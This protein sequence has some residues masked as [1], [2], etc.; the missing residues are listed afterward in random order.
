MVMERMK[1]HGNMMSWFSFIAQLDVGAYFF[2]TLL[3]LI[4]KKNRYI[5]TSARKIP[6]SI[7]LW[8]ES[9]KFSFRQYGISLEG[10]RV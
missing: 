1:D 7:I 5:P 8:Q 9:I 3:I 6:S 2:S 4:Y 10:M